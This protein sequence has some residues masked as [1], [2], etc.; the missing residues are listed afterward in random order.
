MTKKAVT[1]KV[2]RSCGAN[3]HVHRGLCRRCREVL[4]G[5][6]SVLPAE[7]AEHPRRPEVEPLHNPP[8]R[9]RGA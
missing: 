3:E 2:C 5:A 8:W 1:Q 7:H 6:G 9:R 4:E